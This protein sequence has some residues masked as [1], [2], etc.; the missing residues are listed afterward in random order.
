MAGY[1]QTFFNNNPSIMGRYRCCRCGGMFTKDQIDVD[2][3]IPKK[4]GG[5]DDM[6]NLQA[7]CKHCNRSKQ[8]NIT[9]G[10]IANTLVRSAISG[11]LGNTL[12]SAAK[13]NIKNALG[14]K[15]KR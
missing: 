5:T 1:R 12:K 2:H 9:G 11:N 3:R 8:D 13:Q 4:L 6:S 15:Y 14:F 7:M 10:D